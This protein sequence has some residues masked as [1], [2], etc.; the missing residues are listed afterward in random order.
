M[1]KTLLIS[2]VLLLSNYNQAS[3]NDVTLHS[4]SGINNKSKTLRNPGKGS[5]EL[6]AND[7]SRLVIDEEKDFYKSGEEKEE[8]EEQKRY[9]KKKFKAFYPKPK[10]CQEPESQAIKMKCANEFIKEKAKFE[11]LYMQG[12]I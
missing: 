8:A 3:G 12:K 11:E 10:E 1:R 6:E 4:F 2:I 7:S 9:K 5:I